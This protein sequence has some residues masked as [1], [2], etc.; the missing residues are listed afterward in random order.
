MEAMAKSARERGNDHKRRAYARAN[1][2]PERACLVCGERVPEEYRR[3][4]LTCSD[5]CKRRYAADKTRR[6]AEANPERVKA[7]AA[8]RPTTEAGRKAEREAKLRSYYKR[9]AENGPEMR[10]KNRERWLQKHY[11]ISIEQYDAMLEAQGGGCALCGSPPSE[12]R[13]LPVDHDHRTMEVR[14]IV[15][16][17]CNS[18]LE[19]FDA[20]PEILTR[21]VAYLKLES[22]DI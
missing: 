10:R 8:K 11:G 17:R 3:T 4:R 14:G 2:K 15:C 1:P 22:Y 13:C 16:F 5:E 9:R 20:H 6:W 19:R 21:L 12:G 7:N 18:M